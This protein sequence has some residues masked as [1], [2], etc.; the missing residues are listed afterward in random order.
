MRGCGAIS[1]LD[2]AL[3]TPQGANKDGLLPRLGHHGAHAQAH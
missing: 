1:T 3:E 2:E